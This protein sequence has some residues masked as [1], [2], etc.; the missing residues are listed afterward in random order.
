MKKI[1]KEK[2]NR[3]QDWE[4]NKRWKKLINSMLNEKVMMIR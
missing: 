2:S 1:A 3:T 4:S